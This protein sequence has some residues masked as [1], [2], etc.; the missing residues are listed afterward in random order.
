MLNSFAKND[1]GVIEVAFSGSPSIPLSLEKPLSRGTVLLNTTDR[2]S[3]PIIDFNTNINPIDSDIFIAIVKYMRK[4]FETTSMQHLTPVEQLP[5]TSVA[6]DGQ[7]RSWLV[8]NTFSSTAHSSGTA[9]MAP[10]ALAGVVS[11]S[12]TVYGVTGLSVGDISIIPMIP[13]THTC[14][15]VYTISQKVSSD[16]KINVLY[17]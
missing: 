4:W 16:V 14:A 7:I 11:P 9:A 17:G 6:T 1:N 15:T 2:Y 5:G 13:A 12:L 10:R 3:E 8:N